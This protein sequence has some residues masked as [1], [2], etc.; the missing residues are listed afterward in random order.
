MM[1]I[2]LVEEGVVTRIIAAGEGWQDIFPDLVGVESDTAN[3]GDTW[4]GE[5]FTG[6]PAPAPTVAD[7]LAER[8]RRL[9]LGF[10]YDF[11]D[12][13]GVHQI[14][15]SAADMSGWDEVTTIAQ[16][17]L[18]TGDTTTPIAII[19]NTGPAEVTPVEWMAVLLAAGA[20]RQPI[21]QAS[22]VLQAADPIPDDY[23]DD[24]H[25]TGGA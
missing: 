5:A 18:A 16:A 25:W 8:E 14:G 4:D 22:F 3:I 24:A 7:V 10:S 15:T 17:R 19:T 6:P 23:A 13:R 21:W 1:R 12:A 20:F 9:A 2:A 11:S